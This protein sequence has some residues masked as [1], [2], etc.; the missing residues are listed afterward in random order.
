MSWIAYSVLILLAWGLW[1]LV[2][3]VAY[4]GGGWLQVYFISSLA[5]FTLALTVFLASRQPLTMNRA[6]IAVA[7]AAGL[8]GGLGYVFFVKALE[9][10]KASAVLPLTALYP[11]V[12]VVAALLVLGEKISLPQAVGVVLAITAAI[13]LS[14]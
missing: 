11:A 2:L 3:K 4:K 9:T 8:L 14:L 7:T 6:Y 12:T 1:G 10:G 13:L 5:S